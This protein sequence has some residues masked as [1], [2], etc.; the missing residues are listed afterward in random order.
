MLITILAAQPTLAAPLELDKF[1]E[2]EALATPA[3]IES[4]AGGRTLADFTDYSVEGIQ[5]E[6]RKKNH[7]LEMLRSIDRSALP[8]KY[9]VTYDVI[10]WDA[11]QFIRRAEFIW[12]QFP[13][14]PYQ[15]LFR[16]PNSV[17]TQ[18]QFRSPHDARRYLHLVDRYAVA[19]SSII[20]YIDDQSAQDIRVQRDA[21]KMLQGWLT[22]FAQAPEDSFAWPSN[23][24]LKALPPGQVA[25]FRARLKRGIEQSINPALGDL[26]GKF[27]IDYQQRAPERNGLYQYPQG[28][29][30][31]RFL[32]QNEM[33][34][35]MS[36]E[37][38]FTIVQRSL[39]QIEQELRVL[40][41]QMGYFGTRAEFDRQFVQ[42][43]EFLAET[44][45]DV[46]ATYMAHMAKIDPFVDKLFCRSLPYGYGVQRAEPKEEAALTFGLAGTLQ[47]PPKKG[48]Y[49]YN[50]SNLAERPMVPAQALIYHELAP[51]HYLQ[52]AFRS[53]SDQITD[54][55]R[56]NGAY[57]EAWADYAQM[58]AYEM[59][60]FDTPQARYARLLFV[61][62]F[63]ARSLA[64]IGVN[65]YG[66]DFEWGIKNLQRYTAEAESLNRR[67]LMRDTTDWQAQILPYA[68]GSQQMLRLR[69]KA[70]FEL[71]E[72]F[73]ERRFN[74]A[75]LSVGSVALGVLA[76]HVDWFIKQEL[77]GGAP[78]IC[79]D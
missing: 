19:V 16:G 8:H 79:N 52:S 53:I 64:D 51:G 59:G 61:S 23:E 25:E 27:D 14:T 29:A 24:R 1:L 36:P 43:P 69:E 57:E 33:L 2:V 78:G 49:F 72:R 35:N 39:D 75:V 30:Y 38:A 40:R 67:S 17:L 55:P 58:L 63:Y 3:L 15:F 56:Q 34:P 9:Q 74:D 13:Y 22:D 54:Y 32:V 12:L 70:R 11:Q 37:E 62:M 7:L 65:Y 5:T 45:A 44:P 77:A 68:I 66:Y 76:S 41:S 48:M 28:K 10:E 47:G 42:R 26:A 71:G 6:V 60:V 21:A 20:D 73:D 46:E 18:F 4:T 31:Y 50:G